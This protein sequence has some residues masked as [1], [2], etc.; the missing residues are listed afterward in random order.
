M[1]EQ[2][3]QETKVSSAR[4]G[5]PKMIWLLANKAVV[6]KVG[7]VIRTYMP[8]LSNRFNIIAKLGVRAHE[9]TFSTHVNTSV[10][11]SQRLVQ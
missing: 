4:P 2:D 11:L 6:R 3:Q 8:K 7:S 10:T 5:M 9:S 1:R